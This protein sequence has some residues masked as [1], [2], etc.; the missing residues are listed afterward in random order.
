MSLLGLL[1]KPQLPKTITSGPPCKT[2]TRQTNR[3]CHLWASSQHLLTLSPLG[4]LDT[5]RLAEPTNF[6]TSGPSCNTL[7]R[8]NNCFLSPLCFLATP[9]LATPIDFVTSGPPCNTST[10][11][12]YRFFVTSGPPCNTSTRNTYRFRYLWASLQHLNC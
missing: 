1:A 7:T 9:Q 5:P 8:K 10:R 2:S 6:V 11:N 4:F 3:F 12:T